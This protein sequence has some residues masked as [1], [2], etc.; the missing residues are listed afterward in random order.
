MDDIQRALEAYNSPNRHNF[1]LDDKSV[2]NLVAV[3]YYLS[4]ALCSTTGNEKADILMTMAN[5]DSFQGNIDKAIDGYSQALLVACDQQKVTLH[6]YL[7]VWYHYQGNPQRVTKHIE[8]LSHLNLLSAK[9]ITSIIDILENNLNNPICYQHSGSLLGSEAAARHA[10]VTLGYKLNNN[11]SI[12]K[13]LTLRLEQT[14]KLAELSP[15][16]VIV[17]TGGVKTAG[18]TEAEQMKKWLVERGI[19]SNRI[20]KEE[21]AANTIENAQHTLVILQRNQIQHATLVSASI[22]VHRS[23]IL[24]ETI[25]QSQK[26]AVNNRQDSHITFDHLAVND[27]LSPCDFPTRQTRINCYIDALRGYGLAAF[28]C[29]EYRQI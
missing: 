3:K 7:A 28:E 20:I 22:H 14:L 8:Q 23:Q 1:K 18:T 15:D 27:G 6:S 26:R 25:Q 17:V 5:V 13:P 12:A 11:G 4:E 16:S 24:F 29:G 19:D 2:S 9:T 10:I 21:K